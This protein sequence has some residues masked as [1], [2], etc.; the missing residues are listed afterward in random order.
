MKK[1]KIKYTT[2][3]AGLL[4]ASAI[5]T[6]VFAFLSWIPKEYAFGGI[7]YIPLAYFIYKEKRWA[8]IVVMILWTSDKFLQIGMSP[9]E[10]N[11]VI[12]RSII[13]WWIGFMFAFYGALKET[14]RV[15]DKNNGIAGDN[16]SQKR[17]SS[18]KALIISLSFVFVIFGVVFYWF[19][20]RSSQIKKQCSLVPLKS[21]SQEK[22]DEAKKF[23][24]A[25]C[26]EGSVASDRIGDCAINRFIISAPLDGQNQ[27][28]SASD[29]EYKKCLR[30]SGL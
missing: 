9:A 6:I 10:T 22:K 3:S 16:I 2:L 20:I 19:A 24:E 5:L 23:V 17:F 14:K 26:P 27:M 12:T 18:L 28:R 8:V 13:F 7:I 25:N 1:T 4:V 11:H 29:D 30:E 21:Y 15:S